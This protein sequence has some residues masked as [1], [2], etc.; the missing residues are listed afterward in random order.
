MTG[1]EKTTARELVRSGPF[2]RASAQAV[3]VGDTVHVAGQVAMDE[4]GA[5]VGAGDLQAQ[6]R[7]VYDNAV[8]A[9]TPL[10]ARLTDVVAETWFV[11]D[12]ADFMAQARPIFELRR[13]LYGGDPPVAQTVVEVRALVRPELQVEVQ[14]VAQL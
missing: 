9:L 11:T 2:A 7:Q 13:S 5:V 3:R 8:A 10:G 4:Q 6:V 12:M 14:F 1:A